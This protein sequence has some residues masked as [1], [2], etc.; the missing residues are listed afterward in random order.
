MTNFIKCLKCGRFK[1]ETIEIYASDIRDDNWDIK[2]CECD[3]KEKYFIKLN[4]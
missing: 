1:K 3:N 4:K 2:P